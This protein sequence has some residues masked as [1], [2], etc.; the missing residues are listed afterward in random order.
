[1][2]PKDL[3]SRKPRPTSDKWGMAT[4]GN[5]DRSATTQN[6]LIRWQRYEA[7]SVAV[8]QHFLDLPQSKCKPRGVHSPLWPLQAPFGGFLVYLGTRPPPRTA[9]NIT[10]QRLEFRHTQIP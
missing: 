6:R 3:A 9:F 8:F 5:Q 7:S 10:S 1:V 2:K 4:S